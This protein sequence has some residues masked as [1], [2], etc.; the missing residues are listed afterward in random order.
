MTQIASIDT[1]TPGWKLMLALLIAG[2]LAI[3]LFATYLLI[4]DR[5]S[6]SQTAEKSIV[7]GW[8]GAQ[9]IAAPVL[10]IP[11][12]TT[13]TVAATD[14]G[15]AAPRAGT[16]WRE[17]TLTPD[18]ADVTTR[19]APERRHRSI[20]DAVV[21]RAETSGRV[22][23]TLPADLARL[24]VARGALAL[25]RAE[26]RF[27]LSDP[28]GLVG[29]PPVI[30]IGGGGQLVLQPGKGPAATGGNGFHAWLDARDL[31]TR[32]ITASF[33][34][35]FRGSQSLAL[36]PEGGDTRWRVAS[37]WPSPSFQGD[38][39]PTD[40]RVDA[41]GFAATWRVGNLAL[42]SGLASTDDAPVAAAATLSAAQIDLVTPVDLYS[43]VNRSVKYGFLFIGFTFAMFWLFD[44]IGGVA[45]AT[46]EYLLIGAGLVL[47]FVMLFAF[48]EV[49]GF[50]AAYVVAAGAIVGLL[51]AYSAAVLRSKGRAGAVAALL[52]AL[53]AVLYVLL[54]LEAYA[55]LIGSV[56]LFVAL[57][58]VMW[59]T[60][61][62]DWH[63]GAA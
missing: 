45:V 4:Y 29:A 38:F 44:V 36:V 17:L 52:A 39:L 12:A 16:V 42:G 21:Y 54:G 34:Y 61:R 23:F 20:Y 3:P 15:A 11:Y 13:A 26:L 56:L 41:H 60:R 31:A 1:R 30:R 9:R 40:H 28:R 24:G 27:G 22:R 25:D 35:S 2:L 7:A 46:V 5:E 18:I 55:L 33:A 48:A 47:F 58:A 37:F 49:I 53:Y 32:P 57:A 62:I 63:A 50:A 51:T 43:E 8:G 6:Q 14:T 19:I 10:V 59:L